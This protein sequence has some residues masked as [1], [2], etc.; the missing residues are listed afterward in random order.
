MPWDF[1]LNFDV[2][3]PSYKYIQQMM[4]VF[5][6]ESLNEIYM[7]SNCS[8]LSTVILPD[9]ATSIG[10]SAFEGSSSLVSIVIS[11]GVTSIGYSAFEDCTSL[12]SVVIP[13]SVVTMGGSVFYGCI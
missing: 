6:A 13:R 11:E 10:E 9:G 1:F 2:E 5:I 7:S 4:Q 3:A 12:V 8:S